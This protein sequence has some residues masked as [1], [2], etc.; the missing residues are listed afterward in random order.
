MHLLFLG[1]L[2]LSTRWLFTSYP[3]IPLLILP[4]LALM[5]TLTS[6]LTSYAIVSYCLRSSSSPR[7]GS[8]TRREA[9]KSSSRLGVGNGSTAYSSSRGNGVTSLRDRSHGSVNKTK[10]F[11]PAAGSRITR[12]MSQ[13]GHSILDS[14]GSDLTGSDTGEL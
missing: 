5:M 11:G 8:S 1:Y 2:G 13:N 10:A 7:S 12:K 3:I 4:P 6:A 9:S 14:T